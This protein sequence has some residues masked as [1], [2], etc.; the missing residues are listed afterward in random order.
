MRT[1]TDLFVTEVLWSGEVNY[2][3]LFFSNMTWINSDLAQFYSLPDPGP[4]W[5]RVELDESRPGILTRSAFLA[6]HAYTGSSAPIKRGHFILKEMLCEELSVPPD[7]NTVI[8]EESEEA[9]TIRE[10]L[11]QH[12][13]DPSCSGCHD[14][15]DPIGFS[16]EHFDAIGAWRDN[17]ESGIPIDATGDIHLGSFDDASELI[18]MAATTNTAKM[19]F[20]RW[21]EMHWVTLIPQI[22]VL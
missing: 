17:W 9:A 4:G 16:F 3:D 15:I 7:V 8:P 11:L 18:A 20:K 12:Q 19:L 22:C 2:E 5:H 14:K 6:A 1:E 13:S 10:R 21:F